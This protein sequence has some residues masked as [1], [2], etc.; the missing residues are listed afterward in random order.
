MNGTINRD[1]SIDEVNIYIQPPK[2][3]IKKYQEEYKKKLQPG[4]QL[5]QLEIQIKPN[6]LTIGIKGNPP[7]LNVMNK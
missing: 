1:Q 3:L 5:P 7:F 4:Q 6:H 2:F